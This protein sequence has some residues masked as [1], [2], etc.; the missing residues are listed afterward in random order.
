MKT[1][2]TG[3]GGLVGSTMEADVRVIGRKPHIPGYKEYKKRWVD[4]SNWKATYN[5]FQETKPTHVIHTAARV[6]GLGANMN[7]MSEFYTQNT[8]INLNVLE[9]ARRAGVEKVVSFL[10]TCIFPDDVEYPLCEHML[11]DG[12]PHTSNFGYSYAKRMLDVHSRAIKEQYGL[13]YIC[14]IPT[15][16]YGPNDNFNLDDSHVVPALIHKC[17]LAKKNKTDLVVWGSGKPIREFIYSEDVG[18]LTQLILDEY[19]GPGPL[20]ISSGEEISIKDLVDLI[21]KA[22][23]FKGKIVFDDSKPDGQYRK[24]T[25]NLLLKTVFPKYKFT[26]LKQGI[27]KTVDWFVENYESCRK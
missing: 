21:V 10:S 1:L 22:M 17:Y 4:L 25:S 20:I 3:A 18:E 9:A 19:D 24:T 27:K 7:Y 16:I 26:K 11:H 2:L 13:N 23:K 15:N 12:A 14:V 5:L 6:G 8:A